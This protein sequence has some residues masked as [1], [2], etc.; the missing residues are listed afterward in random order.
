MDLARMTPSETIASTTYCLASFGAEYL[1]YQP[2][3]E[4]FTVDLSNAPGEFAVEWFNPKTAQTTMA[5]AV[6]GGGV[7]EFVPPGGGPAVLY[8]KAKD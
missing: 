3:Q 6:K 8:L 4:A 1:V 2:E 5:E 7:R